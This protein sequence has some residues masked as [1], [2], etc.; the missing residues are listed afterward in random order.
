MAGPGRAGDRRSRPKPR[1]GARNGKWIE[2]VP[3]FGYGHTF[4]LWQLRGEEII[5]TT[6]EER[7]LCG[8]PPEGWLV[9]YPHRLGLPQMTPFR[10]NMVH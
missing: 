9:L 5:L 8:G 7:D 3:D 1:S 4:G 6:G 2:V 10:V